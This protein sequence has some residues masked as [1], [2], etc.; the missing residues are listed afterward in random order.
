METIA[1]RSI[2]VKIGASVQGLLA[3]L[4]TADKAAQDWGNKTLAYVEKNS[5]S[6]N[7]LAGN[8]GIVGAGLTGLAVLAVKTF[9]DFDAAM[10]S[11]QASTM[12]TAGNMDLL[13]QAAIDAGSR[14][15]Y[16]ATEA[17]GAIEELAKAGVSTADILGGGL[18]GALDLAAS[19][20]IDVGDAAE[21][22]ATA[23][24]QFGL[25]G[26]DV[27]HIAD[28]LAAGAG[29]AQGGVGDLGAAL[30]QAGLVANQTGLSIEETTAG[31]TAFAS[32]GLTGSDAG[33]SFKSMLQRL[34]PQ[35]KEAETLM[36]QLGISAYDA[37]GNFIGLSEFAGNLQSSLKALTPEQ[38]NAALATIF[39][40][41]AVRAA[42]VLYEQ[43]AAGIDEWTAAVN[44]QGYA[45]EQAA[46]RMDNLKGDI[47]GLSGSFETALI[48]LGE[49][50]N[51]PLRSLVQ[52]LDG[53]VDSFNGLSDGAQS[54]VLWTIGGAGL[55]T[56]GLAGAIKMTTA[57]G[58]TVS[59]LKNIGVL[60][61]AGAG[62]IGALAAGA[63]KI[64]GVAAGLAA[65][66]VAAGKLVDAMNGAKV[67]TVEQFADALGRLGETGDLAD[68]N[69]YIRDASRAVD[70]LGQN[71]SDIEDL[72]DAIDRAFNKSASDNVNDWV[73]S[74]FGASTAGTRLADTFDNIDEAL[75]G[76]VSSGNTQ[77]A[78][79][80]F[81]EIRDEMLAQGKTMDEVRAAFPGYTDALLQAASGANEAAPAQQAYNDAMA[82]GGAS[83]TQYAD[84]LEEA[85]EAQREQTDALLTARDAQRGFEAAIDDA[86][87]ALTENGATLDIT[88]EKGRE[89]Q[90]ALDAIAESGIKATDAMRENGA[91][92]GELQGQM[93][94]T[95][96]RFIAA[97][98]AFGMSADEAAALA[99]QMNL[100]PDAVTPT[101][102]LNDQASAG[103]DNIWTKITRLP[104]RTVTVNLKTN[105]TTVSTGVGNMVGKASGG[106]VFGPGTGTS[107]SIPA[108]LS[109]G[110]HVLTASD[111]RKMGG[112]AAV[113]AMRAAVQAG[114]GY[115]GGG[116]VRQYVAPAVYQQPSSG[117]GGSWAGNTFFPNATIVAADTQGAVK[118]TRAMFRQEMAGVVI[119]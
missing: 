109:N 53:A 5:A 113:Y 56:L 85:I 13:R 62:R 80:S 15:V 111:V 77:A 79:L 82:D 114:R 43:G 75:A 18:D 57:L 17:A 58:D 2:T 12:E 69:Q 51:G 14:T 65:A 112:H 74:L 28:L 33:T 103:L 96:D 32:A 34:T 45:A 116:E 101:V 52:A 102:A 21:I 91:T 105:E 1:D 98:Q 104:D 81:R 38:R 31:L 66:A 84:A 3:G 50:A 40:S 37:G 64:A 97:A 9:A 22:A 68:L 4:K 16:S 71:V 23:M 89:N 29:K 54:A 83:A 90:A 94:T 59:A 55:F 36:K 10:S 110:E 8:L 7:H 100:I 61:E 11:V 93:Q 106:A 20:A 119:P 25:K 70:G 95:R 19:G 30:Q 35:S 78:F 87:A 44:D 117:G 88:T 26:S 86:S 6:L 27:T 42:N 76:M 72:G 73:A 24:T 67:G 60:S 41:D 108:R 118:E 48:N 46:I 115:A 63:A 107:D 92:Q 39:G 99:D 47:E 49:G